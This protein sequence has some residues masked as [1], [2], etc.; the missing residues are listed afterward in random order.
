MKEYPANAEGHERGGA[1]VLALLDV[2]LLRLVQDLLVE[3]LEAALNSLVDSVPAPHGPCP[4]QLWLSV[5]GP[6]P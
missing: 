4:V 3:R 5:S 1:A 6:Y 2:A